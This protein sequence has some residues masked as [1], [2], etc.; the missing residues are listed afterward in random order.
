MRP[1]HRPKLVIVNLQWTPKDDGASLKIHGEMAQKGK[2]V[3][4]PYEYHNDQC[5]QW[6]LSN[7][8]DSMPFSGHK[9]MLRSKNVNLGHYVQ[10]F[11]PIFFHTCYASWILP[12]YSS[13]NALGRGWGGGGGGGGHRVSR[14]KT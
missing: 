9:A 13:V 6:C 4:G 7:Q 10:T 2:A 12:F 3:L 8:I 1:E 11:Q 5:N 14:N